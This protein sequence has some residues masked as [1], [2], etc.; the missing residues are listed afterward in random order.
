MKRM[1]PMNNSMKDRPVWQLGNQMPEGREF[2]I[3]HATHTVPQ[4]S[5]YHSHTFY[6]LYFILRGSIRVIVEEMDI[7]PALGDVLIYPPHCMHRVTH[8][9]PSQPYERFYIYLSREFLASISTEGYN[10][11]EVLDRLTGTHRYCL[12]PGEEAVQALVPIADEIIQGAED[13]SPAG[14]LTNRCRMPL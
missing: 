11:I 14:I 6:E 4:P 10:F 9:D 13:T 3:Y 8:S 1:L 2:E 5:I 7:S 12:Q